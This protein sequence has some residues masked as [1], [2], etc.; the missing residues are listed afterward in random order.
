MR[1]GTPE[2]FGPTKSFILEKCTSIEGNIDLCA[3]QAIR[4]ALRIRERKGQPAA[5]AIKEKNNI[6][7]ALIESATALISKLLDVNGPERFIPSADQG[8]IPQYFSISK[9]FPDQPNPDLK[10]YETLRFFRQVADRDS[11]TFAF[12]AGNCQKDNLGAQGKQFRYDDIFAE[13]DALSGKKVVMTYGLDIRDIIGERISKKNIDDYLVFCL[14]SED[15][16]AP[17][18]SKEDPLERIVIKPTK[19]LG[20]LVACTLSHEGSKKARIWAPTFD[21][22]L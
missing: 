5:S 4:T 21:V 3:D 9:I 16:V 12:F 17:K 6:S 20:P 15:V 11:L 2:L 22:I 19:Y 10:T 18:N 13:L 8:D 1:R 7:C 14:S